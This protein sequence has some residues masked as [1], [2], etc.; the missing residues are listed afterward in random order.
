[1]I[2]RYLCESLTMMIDA[3]GRIILICS[4]KVCLCLLLVRMKPFSTQNS[5]E[6]AS[7]ITNPWLGVAA[8]KQSRKKNLTGSITLSK[9]S[10]TP[11][12][13]LSGRSGRCRHWWRCWPGSR[14]TRLGYCIWY[15]EIGIASAEGGGDR[16]AAWVEP[17]SSEWASGST[18][19][20]LLIT[21]W[22]QS[23]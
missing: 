9:R 2:C 5:R 6:S 21:V 14:L 4:P 22:W 19:E 10:K 7:N 13:Q 15:V 1:M 3:M 12:E 20:C 16:Q 18:P 11:S 17:A 8:A 23:Q